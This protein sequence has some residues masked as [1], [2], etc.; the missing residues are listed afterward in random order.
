M[1]AA[2]DRINDGFAHEVPEPICAFLVVA[3]SPDWADALA[4]DLETLLIDHANCE[5]KAA[6][7]AL[8]LMHRYPE[9]VN[10]IHRMSRLAREE[11]RHYE[12]VQQRMQAHGIA[13]RHLSASGYA[14]GLKA[15]ALRDEPLRLVD[16]LIIGGLIEARSCER[17]ALIAPRLPESLARFYRGLLAS[18]ARHFEHYLALAR[19]AAERDDDV[20]TARL[21]ILRER[22]QALIAMPTDTLRFH[23]GP[24]A[25]N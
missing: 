4:A 3:S 9:R 19:D 11:L 23:S 5:L 7:S 12:Q 17:F 24:P 18:E 10:L 14:A 20:V 25:A 2:A 6:A 8:A 22:E 15:V 21:A 13:M 16:T 1:S